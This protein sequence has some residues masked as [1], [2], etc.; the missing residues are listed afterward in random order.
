MDN[1][2]KYMMISS[3]QQHTHSGG[4]IL[5][6]LPAVLLYL[7]TE[8]STHVSFHNSWKWKWNWLSIQQFFQMRYVYTV[9]GRC[10]N[11]FNPDYH[12]QRVTNSMS[13]T[14]IALIR[15]LTQ[16]F[17]GRH[18]FRNIYNLNT[19]KKSRRD[20]E[21][22]PDMT[23]KEPEQMVPT[24]TIGVC[25][26]EERNIYCDVL[27]TH[28]EE[29]AKMS[30]STKNACTVD[31]YRIRIELYSYQTTAFEIKAFVDAIVAKYMQ[32]VEGSR[33]NKRF[34]Y[35]ML[36]VRGNTETDDGDVGDTDITHNGIVWNEI[37]FETVKTFDT[38]C[39]KNKPVVLDKINFFLN[40]REWYYTH[41]VPYTLGIGLHGPPGTG[42]TSFIK[43]L[44]RHTNRHIVCIS[45]KVVT[46]R[47]QLQSVFYETR[48]NTQNSYIGFKDKIIV[49][50]DI[51]C[52]GKIVMQ[53]DENE[54]FDDAQN[55]T[56]SLDKDADTPAIILAKSLNKM[57][58]P[59]GDTPV[60]RDKALTLDDL[61]GMWDGIRETPGRIIVVTSNFYHKLDKALVRPGR[62]DLEIETTVD[63]ANAFSMQTHTLSAPEAPCANAL[64]RECTHEPSAVTYSYFE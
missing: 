60:H 48:Y 18:Q 38:V 43:A 54:P 49:F 35:T 33:R 42:K 8:Y 28:T 52:T 12:T 57:M 16:E 10:W 14:Y 1:M 56:A 55:D 30:V 20:S 29:T 36:S 63:D 31:A 13:P 21:D 22:T 45:M 37:P 3:L 59:V 7:I 64:A 47:N 32:T 5:S 50:E 25:V 15:Y 41:G 53:R 46:T 27:F 51:D 4:M 44:A 19:Y 34:V 39:L 2:F 40:N 26:S 11:A 62:I 23:D 24:D 58:A 9:E 6:L 61:L 17:E